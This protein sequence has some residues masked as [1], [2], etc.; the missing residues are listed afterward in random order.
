MNFKTLDQGSIRSVTKH[1]IDNQVGQDL[2][3]NKLINENGFA[4][5]NQIIV[6]NGTYC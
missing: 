1:Q 2:A 3:K 6:F 5:T 4:V